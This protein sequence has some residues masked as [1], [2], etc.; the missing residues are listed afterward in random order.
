MAFKPN[1]NQ[2]RAERDRAKR[3]KRE[4][5]L[6]LQQERTAQRKVGEDGAPVAEDDET[7]A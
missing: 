6:K 2:Q 1:Y 7:P 3:A 5:K 4:E